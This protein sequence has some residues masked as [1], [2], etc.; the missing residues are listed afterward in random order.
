[1]LKILITI[2]NADKKYECFD[3]D[4]IKLKCLRRKIVQFF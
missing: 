1:M 2:N 4:K 3:K